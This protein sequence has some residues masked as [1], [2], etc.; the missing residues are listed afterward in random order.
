MPK[1]TFDTGDVK[2]VQPVLSSLGAEA[3][4]VMRGKVPDNLTDVLIKRLMPA[5]RIKLANK[6]IEIALEGEGRTSLDAIREIWDR[7]DG[8]ARQSVITARAEDDPMMVL[9]REIYKADPKLVEDGTVE[10]DYRLLGPIIEDD[11]E[12]RTEDTE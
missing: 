10:G 8:K 3:N 1:D 12:T 9:L 7:V 6:L 11:T 2:E 4:R 5:V